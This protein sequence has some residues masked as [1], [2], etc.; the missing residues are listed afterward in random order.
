MLAQEAGRLRRK[1]HD[2]V[3]R[4]SIELEVKFGFRPA[5]VPVRPRPEFRSFQATSRQCLPAHDDAHPRGLAGDPRLARDGAGDNHGAHRKEAGAPFV[6]ARED[7]D[8]VARR[9][10]P[11]AVHRLLLV[12][13]Q[14]PGPR[15]GHPGLYGVHGSSRCDRIVARLR[16]LDEAVA[17]PEGIGHRGDPAPRVL[18]DARAGS[19]DSTTRSKWAGV[20]ENAA[21]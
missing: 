11:A 18:A 17:V 1:T 16:E 21:Q 20:S 15:L 5:V 7:E 19:N 10:P 3:G 14:K 13:Y 6:L 4:L 12:E 8:G 9:D 2:L